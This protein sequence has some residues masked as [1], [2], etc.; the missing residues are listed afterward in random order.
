MSEYNG[1]PFIKIELERVK[2]AAYHAFH[3][4]NKDFDKLIART[5]ESRL[6]Q[7]WVKNEVSKACDQV[8]REAIKAVIDD[9][10]IKQALQE[11]LSKTIR[12]QLD[13]KNDSVP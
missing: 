4:S 8:I 9:H 13:N 11:S 3:Q 10:T 5:L 1:M 2:Q 12:E 6:T 7:Q